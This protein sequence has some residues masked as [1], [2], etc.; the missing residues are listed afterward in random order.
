MYAFLLAL[1]A[2]FC[3]GLAPLFGKVGLRGVNPADALAARTLVTVCFVWGWFIARGDWGKIATISP[4]GW[5][6]LSLEAFFATFAGDL[7]YYAA[8]KFGDIGQ[9]GLVLAASPLV[10]LCVGS[11]FLQ[12]QLTAHKLLG[13]A[14]IVVGII[15][16]GFDA[17]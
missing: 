14:L 10:T 16:V 7:A 8:I 4:R 1:Y 17:V 11:W 9:T 6:F 5:F 3:W 2:A 13:A 15:L 12:E